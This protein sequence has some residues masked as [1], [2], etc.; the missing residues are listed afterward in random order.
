MKNKLNKVD[1]SLITPSDWKTLGKV[2]IARK[3]GCAY[4]LVSAYLKKRKGSGSEIARPSVHRG[5]RCDW[6][7][8]TPQDWRKMINAE[9][10]KKAGYSVTSAAIR[11]RWLID[12]DRKA[13]KTGERFVCVRTGSTA[14]IDWKP[15]TPEDWRSMSD[16]EIARKLG[17]SVSSAMRRRRHLTKTP[18]G[19]Q[20]FTY[21]RPVKPPG[22]RH[23]WEKIERADWKAMNDHQIARKVGCGFSTAK[24]RRKWLIATAAEAVEKA[25]AFICEQPTRGKKPAPDWSLLKPQD[26]EMSII[27]I[28]R[29]LGCPTY[30]GF[31]PNGR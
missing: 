7:K 28:A 11:R 30:R 2:E 10:A 19:K 22:S 18:S 26:W 31:L 14:P 9:I 6:S 16:R 23:D 24:N 15:I 8:I 12:Q 17:C 25:S 4:S 5:S 3:A 13:G 1:W 21:L 29:K 20:R 27:Q